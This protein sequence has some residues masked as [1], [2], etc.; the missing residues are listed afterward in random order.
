MTE[1]H[2]PAVNQEHHIGLDEAVG[3]VSPVSPV[4]TVLYIPHTGTA[5]PLGASSSGPHRNNPK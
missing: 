3:W 5:L 2:T 4:F 1:S